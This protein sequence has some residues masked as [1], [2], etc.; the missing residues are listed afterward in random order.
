MADP[1]SVSAS[2]AGLITIADAVFSR[3]FKYVKAVKGAPKELSA[4][5]LAMGAL[6]GILHNLNLIILQLD[7]E[8]FDTTIQADHITSCLQTVEKVKEILDKFEPSPGGHSMK[9]PKRLKWP[10]SVTEAKDLCT[11]IEEHKATLSLALTADG[12]SALLQSLSRQKKLQNGIDNIQSE[13]RQ[14]REIETR[15]AITEDRRKVLDWIQ[16]YDPHQNHQ[17]SLRLR[18]PGTGL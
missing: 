12:L 6:S 9:P 14:R 8:P 13:L 10:F 1:L 15:I 3:T 5:T 7:R 11:E 4:L 18:R 2:V 17:M 16:L